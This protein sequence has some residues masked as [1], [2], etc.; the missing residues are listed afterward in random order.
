MPTIKTKSRL[1]SSKHKPKINLEVNNKKS[2]L[3]PILQTFR[4]KL[5]SGPGCLVYKRA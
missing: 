5:L 4:Q 3:T 2:N 1:Q